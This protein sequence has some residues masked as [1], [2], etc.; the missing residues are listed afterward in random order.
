MKVTEKCDVYS[1]GVVTMEVMIGRHPGDLISTLL[2]PDSS[3]SSSMPPIA[4][5]TLLKDVLDQRISLPRTGAAE[6]VVH[7]MKIAIACLHPNPPVSAYN[8]K[9]L[10]GAHNQV[11]STPKGILH[12]NFG[13]SLLI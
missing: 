13:R 4:Q 11:A 5:H 12:N 2:S 1:F 7:M 6:G 10:F 8:G 9:N 3:S